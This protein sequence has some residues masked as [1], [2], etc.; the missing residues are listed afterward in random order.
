MYN[1]PQNYRTAAHYYSINRPSPYGQPTKQ[2]KRDPSNIRFHHLPLCMC[3]LKLQW[4]TDLHSSVYRPPPRP[5]L[6]DTSTRSRMGPHFRDNKL[7][8]KWIRGGE[9]RWGSKDQRKRKSP[10]G[11]V[12]SSKW[13]GQRQRKGGGEVNKKKR[14]D[15]IAWWQVPWASSGRP[16]DMRRD[17]MSHSCILVE[18]YKFLWQL[19]IAH[20]TLR[21]MLRPRNQMQLVALDM[22]L[23]VSHYCCTCSQHASRSWC[24]RTRSRCR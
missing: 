16:L 23:H 8:G 11:L 20:L 24:T 1:L 15:I 9:A 14:Y 7:L 5:D 17:M 18:R 12:P 13:A 10:C 4:R 19:S 3:N 21:Q 6:P 2:R 22:T